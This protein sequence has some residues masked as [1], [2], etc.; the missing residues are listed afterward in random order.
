MQLASLS[1]L[2]MLL[3]TLSGAET[4]AQYVFPLKI[5]ADKQHLA[6]QRNKPFPILGRTAWCILSAPEDGYQQFLQNSLWYGYNAIEISALCHWPTSNHPPFNGQMEAPFLKRL[7]GQ[8]WDGG[9][10]FKNIQTEAPNLLTPNEKYWRYLDSLL[11]YC[12]RRGIM[13]FLFPAYVGYDFKEQGWGQE[14]L[15]N[16]PERVQAYGAW[17]ARRY[18]QRKNIVWMLLGDFGRFNEAQQQAEAALIRG[19]KS[20][21]GQQSALYTAESFSGENANENIFFG[22][23]MT[24]NGCYTWDTV[25]T[26]PMVCRRGYASKPA[27]PSFLL[28]EPYDEEGPDGNHYNPNA[29]QPVRRFQWWGWLSTVGGYVAGNGYIWPFTD[30]VWRNHL[31]TR[32]TQDMGRLNRFIKQQPWWQLQPSGLGGM[33]ELVA[34]TGNSDTLASFVAASAS[35]DRTLLIA[36]LPPAHRGPVSVNMGVLKGPVRARWYDPT[37]AQWLPAAPGRLANKGLHSF[38]PPGL[39]N[40]GDADWVLELKAAK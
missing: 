36:Y 17:F 33:P 28:E 13:V 15:A 8:P 7:N 11:N 10:V 16:G 37:N 31:D 23:E 21:K 38:T 5:S 25:K 12:G 32:A 22:K 18:K 14:L 35:K 26:V 24:I 27:M 6:D 3:L 1:F 29:V 19:L 34:D 40:A 39:N 2:W 30:T 4:H 20:V 9:L